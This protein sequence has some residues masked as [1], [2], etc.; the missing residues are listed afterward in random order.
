MLRYY[1]NDIQVVKVAPIIIEII[2]IIII[3]LIPKVLSLPVLIFLYYLKTF[4]VSMLV[5]A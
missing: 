2:I 3:I 1:P 5:T 4:I